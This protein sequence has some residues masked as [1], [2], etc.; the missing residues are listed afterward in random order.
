MD[1]IQQQTNQS[2]QVPQQ[3]GY[4]VSTDALHYEHLFSSVLVFSSTN[5]NN[6]QNA[7][8][9]SKLLL[10]MLTTSISSN[11]DDTQ[12]DCDDNSIQQKRYNE[13]II[14][15]HSNTNY[16]NNTLYNNYNQHSTH[17]NSNN[18]HTNSNNSTTTNVIT[19]NLLNKFINGSRARGIH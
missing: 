5:N 10:P 12:Y 6:K 14:E 9:N 3:T 19:F 18:N 8:S 1:N 2:R 15:T 7:I 13:Q 4:S 17:S 11:D 16:N